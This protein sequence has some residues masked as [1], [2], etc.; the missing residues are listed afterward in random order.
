M[1]LFS[2]KVSKRDESPLAKGARG[3]EIVI[4]YQSYAPLLLQGHSNES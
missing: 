2:W 1:G 4:K 3:I